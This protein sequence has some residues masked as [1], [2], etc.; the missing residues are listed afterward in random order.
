MLLQMYLFDLQ[1]FTIKIRKAMRI[2]YKINN[3]MFV[4]SANALNR[5]TKCWVVLG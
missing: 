5:T 4:D 3:S 2:H 1:H